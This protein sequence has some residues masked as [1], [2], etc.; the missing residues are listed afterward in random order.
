MSSELDQTDDEFQ[1]ELV[2]LFGQEAQEWLREIH[3][4]LTELEAQPDL[5][6]HVQL[7]ESVVRGITTLG[8]SAATVNLVDVERAAF[9]LLPFIDTLKDRTTASQEDYDAVRKQF[10]IVTASVATATGLMAVAE[11][12]PKAVVQEQPESDLLSLLNAL[13]AFQEQE[14][15]SGRS[16][17]GLVGQVMQR[18][19]QGARQGMTTISGCEFKKILSDFR[20]IDEQL[21]VLIRAQLPNVA[22]T[23]HHLDSYGN[24][25]AD[26]VLNA[27]VQEIER[28]QSCARQA[29][30]A[31]LVTFLTGLH[32]FLSLIIQHRLVLAPR[33]VAAVE[34]RIR[35]VLT[36]FE[37]WCVA[38]QGE[39][40]AMSRLLPAA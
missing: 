26:P 6:R 39:C 10:E 25:D 2:A 35:S 30:A 24:S 3:A 8:G 19:E 5:D 37:G 9:A 33:R 23:L 12:R 36:A 21:L 38:G 11:L 1:K 7:V 4:A 40:D 15:P 28:L 22:Q 16:A 17:R 31:S 18:L 14:G 20:D 34:A 29:N 27:C 32:S 13:R